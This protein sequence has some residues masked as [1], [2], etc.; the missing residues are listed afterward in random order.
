M[1]ELIDFLPRN[2][3][4]HNALVR[5]NDSMAA[6]AL[7]AVIAIHCVCL[8]P[9]HKLPLPRPG[10]FDQSSAGLCEEHCARAEE[11]AMD[12]ESSIAGT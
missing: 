6:T 1:K 4:A 5:K 3:E 12:R 10:L 2:L 8:F 7:M 11:S 9:F